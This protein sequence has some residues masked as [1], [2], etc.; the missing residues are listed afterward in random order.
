MNRTRTFPRQQLRELEAELLSERRRLERFMEAETEAAA[1]DRTESESI[2]AMVASGVSDVVQTRAHARYDAIVNALRRLATGEYG[3][4]L[5][6]ERPIPYGRLI[7]M[8]EA[9]HCVA[10]GPRA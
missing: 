10:C 9:L 4:C 6:C 8:P 7:V 2:D 3:T 5:G 1:S